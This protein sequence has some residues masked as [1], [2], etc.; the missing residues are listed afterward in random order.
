MANRWN[1]DRS[2]DE[3]EFLKQ[4]AV[5]HDQP[6]THSSLR[7]ATD[8]CTWSGRL[9]IPDAWENPELA[10]RVHQC[11]EKKYRAQQPLCWVEMHTPRYPFYED[12]DVIGSTNPSE[13]PPEQLLMDSKIFWNLRAELLHE[14]FPDIDKLELTL[15]KASGWNK[16]KGIWK[17]S[18]H[19]VWRQLVVDSDRSEAV[20]NA[21]VTEF[22][23]RSKKSG[24]LQDLANQL[25]RANECNRW[26]AIFDVTVIKGGSCRMPFN[27]KVS[28]QPRQAEGRSI[29]PVGVWTFDFDERGNVRWFNQLHSAGDLSVEEWLQRG[30][31][32][33]PPEKELSRFKPLKSGWKSPAPPEWFTPSPYSSHRSRAGGRNANKKAKSQGEKWEAQQRRRRRYF[34]G[35]PQQFM[36][37]IDWYL[38]DPDS[39][40]STLLPANQNSR[41]SKKWRW[42]SKRLKGAVE[43]SED[44][45]VF[46][47]GNEAQQTELL[48]LIRQFTEEWTGPV[49]KATKKVIQ[50]IQNRRA[51]ARSSWS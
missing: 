48:Q 16:D 11:I 39:H 10:R 8:R 36:K 37:Q 18:F 38:Y 41:N 40:E 12:I 35:T 2:S 28:G 13:G 45:E 49:P 51:A 30:S 6:Y 26:N 9:A 5:Y 43:I 25:R 27:D 44:G 3:D 50:N 22:E 17:A 34:R 47:Q 24:P 14:M 21:T 29:V 42:S 33:I 23:Q 7:G 31:V 4:F 20:R 1:R 19:T 15:Y 46:I 32:R